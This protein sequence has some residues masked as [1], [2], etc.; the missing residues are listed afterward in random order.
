MVHEATDR[1]IG[2]GGYLDQVQIPLLR[3]RQG[4]SEGVDPHLLA[5]LINQAYFSGPDLLVDSVS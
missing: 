5:C 2:V 3:K 4:L 1:G